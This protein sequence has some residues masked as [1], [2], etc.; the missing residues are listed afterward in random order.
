MSLNAQAQDTL[1]T[2]LGNVWNYDTAAYG[3]TAKVA[4]VFQ[5]TTSA[6]FNNNVIMLRA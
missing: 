5:N 4:S 1:T 6:T 3:D 2:Y